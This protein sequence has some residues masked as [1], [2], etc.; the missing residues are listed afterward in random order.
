M[1]TG[2]FDVFHHATDEGLAFGVAQAVHI[3]LD[4]VVQ[5]AVQQHRGVVAHL[6]GLAHVTLQIALLMHDFHRAATQHI[7]RAHH[8]RIAECAGF[9]QGF[10]LGARCC[11]RWLLKG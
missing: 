7:T 1:H 9:F 3:A 4:G 6:H 8:Q 2:L 11:I 5:E 10:G